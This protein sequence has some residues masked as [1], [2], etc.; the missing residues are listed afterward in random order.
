MLFC[1]VPIAVVTHVQR[2]VKLVSGI[3]PLSLRKDNYKEGKKQRNAFF[4][5]EVFCVNESHNNIK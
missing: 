5:R 3:T 1:W 2:V 4:H